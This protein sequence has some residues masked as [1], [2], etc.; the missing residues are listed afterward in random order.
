MKP[1]LATRADCNF[2]RRALGVCYD[3]SL[4]K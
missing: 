1:R 4:V 2:D 3:F